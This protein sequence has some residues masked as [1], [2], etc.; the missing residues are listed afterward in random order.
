MGEIWTSSDLRKSM[1]LNLEER[2]GIKSSFYFIWLHSSALKN[3]VLIFQM[4][5]H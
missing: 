2:L 1:W 5:G 4:E 3:S